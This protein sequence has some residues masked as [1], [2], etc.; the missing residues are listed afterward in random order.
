M[1]IFSTPRRRPIIRIGI[2]LDNTLCSDRYESG[3]IKNC[4]LNPGARQKI[5]GWRRAGHKVIFFTHRS[6]DKHAQETRE[7]LYAQNIAYDGIIFDKP[8]FDVYIGNEARQ[9]TSWRRMRLPKK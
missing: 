7:W 6:A 2:D 8:H 3:G 4:R 9:F 5:A 1:F